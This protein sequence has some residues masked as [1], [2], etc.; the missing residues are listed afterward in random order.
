MNN[1]L[2]HLKTLAVLH[3]VWAGLQLF[4]SMFFII[5]I[6]MGVA[7]TQIDP[8]DFE[9]Q[10]GFGNQAGD[11]EFEDMFNRAEKN[12]ETAENFKN[13]FGGIFICLG[14]GGLLLGVAM[15]TFNIMVGRNLASQKGKT[16]CYVISAIN[17]LSIPLGTALGIFTFVVLGRPSVTA[18][19][20]GTAKGL[21][22]PYGQPP[23]NQP[24]F[25]QPPYG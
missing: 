16:F 11:K 14:V 15:G 12:K 13:T 22:Q 19:F 1:D 9:R 20:D 23:Y 10:D 5:Y 18:M 25:N 17:C 4:S 3:Y 24:P 21:Q 7:F 2:S 6:V 8:D